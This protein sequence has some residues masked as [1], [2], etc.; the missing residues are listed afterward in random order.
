MATIE[1]MATVARMWTYRVARGINAATI[2]EKE[3]IIDNDNNNAAPVKKVSKASAPNHMNTVVIIPNTTA[4]PK[5]REQV[6]SRLKYC[7][8]R[9]GCEF[10]HHGHDKK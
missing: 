6:C 1:A 5:T 4:T 3:D 9:S 2:V 7:H 8:V 10:V